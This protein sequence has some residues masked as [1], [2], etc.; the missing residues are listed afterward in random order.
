MTLQHLK[1][2]YTVAKTG[3]F[4]KASAALCLTQPAVTAH[5]KS[6]ESYLGALLFERNR[7]MH[8]I[9]LT[10]QGEKLLM[11]VER[12]FALIDEMEI[13]FKEM[14]TLHKGG[15]VA[16]GTTAVI[17]IYVL[18]SIFRQFRAQYPEI[19]LDN[20]IGN[21]Q[22]IL[23]MV[24]ASEVEIG[25][26]RKIQEFPQHLTATLFH[27]EQL[28]WIA[29]PHHPLTQKENV[30]LEDLRGMLFIHREAGTRTRVQIE[31]WLREH[32]V[33][34]LV[35]IEVGH[36]EAVKKAVEEGLGISIVPEIVVK[37]E[38]QTNL[39]KTI[40]IAQFDLSAEYYLVHLN[41]RNLSNAT[42]AFLHALKTNNPLSGYE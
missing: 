13:A 36:I 35:S 39:V 8:K 25:I 12:I 34:Q 23:N 16:I 5:I 17:G 7:V 10:Y 26:I 42:Q 15:K 21:S 38:L 24:L 37:R 33:A 30:S 1:T 19:T 9:A 11:Y 22:S 41:D 20:R 28:L 27:R 31:Q 3:S 18:P 2:F 4:T 40:E 32:Q 29:A 6:L 14:K